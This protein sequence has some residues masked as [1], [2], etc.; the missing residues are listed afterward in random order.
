MLLL[1]ILELALQASFAASVRG[2]CGVTVYGANEEGK[3]M[4]KPAIP[5]SAARK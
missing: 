2:A 1:R 5:A 3:S 4:G